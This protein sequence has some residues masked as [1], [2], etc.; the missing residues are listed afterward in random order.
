MA[1][2]RASF[3]ASTVY[4]RTSRG[5]RLNDTAWRPGRQSCTLAPGYHSYLLSEAGQLQFQLSC[6]H[7]FCKH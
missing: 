7:R 4:E 5:I 2:V 6:I 3:R 1:S